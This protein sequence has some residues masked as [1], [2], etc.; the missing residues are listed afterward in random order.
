MGRTTHSFHFNTFY[1]SLRHKK[2]P[3]VSFPLPHFPNK[4]TYVAPRAFMVAGALFKLEE[5]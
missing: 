1:G 3:S 4:K 2:N 5:G